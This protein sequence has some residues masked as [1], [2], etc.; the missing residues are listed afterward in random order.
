MG[1]V[2]TQISRL[3]SISI[4]KLA[5][6]LDAILNSG[7]NLEYNTCQLFSTNAVTIQ[8]VGTLL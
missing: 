1:W 4:H 5:I 7:W 8:R 2:L 6:R 3:N